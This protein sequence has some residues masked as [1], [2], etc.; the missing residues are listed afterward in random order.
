[1][2]NQYTYDNAHTQFGIDEIYIH[3]ELDDNLLKKLQQRAELTLD[4]SDDFILRNVSK[5]II[6]IF[7]KRV[8]EQHLIYKFIKFLHQTPH[9][10]NYI[11]SHTLLN[12]EDLFSAIKSKTFVLITHKDLTSED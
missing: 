2:S 12:E 5:D 4:G 10:D 8:Q 6:L 11:E 3:N 9:K 7:H 1:M